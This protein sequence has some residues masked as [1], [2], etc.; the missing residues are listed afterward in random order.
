MKRVGMPHLFIST[1][2]PSYALFIC[3]IRPALCFIPCCKHIICPVVLINTDFYVFILTFDTIWHNPIYVCQHNNY[4]ELAF[5][6]CLTMGLAI[7]PFS[8]SGF[9]Y[10]NQKKE[11]KIFTEGTLLRI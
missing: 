4:K 7:T 11:K 3:S 5:T 10:F 8:V 2:Q 9:M 6:P 1:Y